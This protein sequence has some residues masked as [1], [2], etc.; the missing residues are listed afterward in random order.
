M[1]KTAITKLIS[2]AACS[3]LL[4]SACGGGATAAGSASSSSSAQSAAVQSESAAPAED[5]AA[6]PTEE[7]AAAQSEAAAEAPAED[8]AASGEVTTL[9]I[10]S[11]QTAQT[12]DVNNAYDGWYLIRFGICQTLTKM[13]DDMSISGWLVEDNYSANDTYDEWTFTIKDGVTFSNGEALT[14]ELAK[15]SLESLFANSVRGTEYFDPESFEADGQTLVIKT[16]NPEPIL[17]NKLADPLFSIID[18][19]ADTSNMTE[20]GPVGTGPY[21]LESFDT[22]S[23]ECI[24]DRNEN[25]WGGEVGTDRIDFYYTEEQTALTNALTTGEFDAV[26]NVS[27]NDIG[28]FEGND[29]YSI[30]KSASG[31]TTHGFMNQNGVLGDKVLRQAILQNLDKDTYCS[32]QL[33]GQYVPGKTLITSSADYG[34]NELTDPNS[35]NPENA[36]KLLDDAGYEDID[37]DGFRET[38]DGEAIDLKFTY[39]TG[40]PE[41]EL[42]VEA[43][44]QEMAA[45]GIKITPDLKDTATVMDKL[46]AGDYDLLC[47]SINVLNCA[48]PENHMKTYFGEGGSYSTTGWHND[49]FESILSELSVTADATKRK[50]LVKE[51]EQILLDDA[52]CIFYCYPLMNFVTK[53]NVSGVLSTPADYY[54]VDENTRIN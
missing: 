50:E 29:A 9:H 23:F 13:N 54:W 12:L 48:D 25:Y 51:A 14:A 10:G 31:R 39:Y 37:G 17:P 8:T 35:Y 49:Q 16:K 36:V 11:G 43:T 27:M 53:S 34:Y 21:V 20:T 18:T 33:Q 45:I 46:S 3:S 5:T 30:V 22:T 41:Q 7:A 32:V 24:V 38:P 1:K 2:L 4:L 19:N 42:L 52:V 44:C 40:R 26:Y 6:A 15:T 28:Q 47:M